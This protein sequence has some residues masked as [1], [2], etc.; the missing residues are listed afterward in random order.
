MICYDG[1]LRSGQVTALLAG[2]FLQTRVF[3]CYPCCDEMH[4]MWGWEHFSSVIPVV[5]GWS[6]EAK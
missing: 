2:K 3:E 1:R 5:M 4:F 6:T